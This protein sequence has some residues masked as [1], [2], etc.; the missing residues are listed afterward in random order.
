[1]EG[2]IPS[3]K[4]P[5]LEDLGFD[6]LSKPRKQQRRVRFPKKKVK[7]GQEVPVKE[8]PVDDGTK[9]ARRAALERAR[10]RN[11]NAPQLEE[12]GDDSEVNY[13]EDENFVEDGIRIEPFNLDK[14]RKEGF[15]DEHG[16]FVEYIDENQSKDAWLDSVEVVDPR[17]YARLN[18]GNEKDSV[19]LTSKDIGMIKKRIASMLEPEE[20]VLQALRRL[21]GGSNKTKA[22]MSTETKLL[23]DKLTEDAN[24]LL[25]HG[26][27]NVY[28]DKQEVFKQEAQRY[29]KLTSDVT[30]LGASS[31]I[32]SDSDMGAPA[33]EAGF[34]M[35]GD[36]DDGNTVEGLGELQNDYVYDETSGYYY[37]SSSGY[38]YD[39]STGLYCNA[40]SGQWYS[41][42]GETGRYD[43]IAGAAASNADGNNA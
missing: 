3:R 36:D 1:M 17:R 21:K 27:H 14:E 20:T 18:K 30:N 7:P 29:E 4:R 32:L 37:S 41:Y 8:A 31:S 6:D 25:E 23:F 40:A 38:Y 26:E 13:D 2:K 24:K 43:E 19:E 12:V 28:H 10:R 34:D 5:Y 15:F 35:F 22:K 9:K 16:N 39:A 11:L 33:A 42:N